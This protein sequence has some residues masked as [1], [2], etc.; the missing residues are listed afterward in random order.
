M[1]QEFWFI[2]IIVS[3]AV[4]AYFVSLFGNI[5]AEK[6][7][8][9]DDTD[10]IHENDTEESLDNNDDPDIN[11]NYNIHHYFTVSDWL[12]FHRQQQHQFKQSN[13]DLEYK[14]SMTTP[15]NVDTSN[16]MKLSSELFIE[17]QVSTP[18]SSSSSTN[19]RHYQNNNKDH[20]QQ[21]ESTPLLPN[22]HEHGQQSSHKITTITPSVIH[23]QPLRARSKT[24]PVTITSTK[25]NRILKSNYNSLDIN[26]PPKHKK[27]KFI[28]VYTIKKELQC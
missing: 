24:L 4:A 27:V 25:S 22:E 19:K 26:T 20:Y 11:N 12:T 9:A 8:I 17:E 18:S 7:L 6:L 21:T 5:L 16:Y 15:V 3:I 1:A 10:T 2:Y 13:I 14:N 23:H 28:I